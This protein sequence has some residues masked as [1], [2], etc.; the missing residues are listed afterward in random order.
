MAAVNVRR[1]NALRPAFRSHRK[2]CKGGD[3]VLQ[4]HLMLWHAWCSLSSPSFPI[5][6]ETDDSKS[7]NLNAWS[8]GNAA[9]YRD[10]FSEDC[11][12]P[13]SSHLADADMDKPVQ[14]HS[15]KQ[16]YSG[17]PRC[18]PS[19]A[20]TPPAG[21]SEDQLRKWYYKF[22]ERKFFLGCFAC[23]VEICKGHFTRPG[24]IAHL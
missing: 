8:S 19:L 24:L 16:P 22:R 2:A 6:M 12:D 18:D 1:T 14:G 3:D 21:L 5:S 7:D 4:F 20:E 23:P 9:G 13:S 17:V 11:N 10:L 15:L